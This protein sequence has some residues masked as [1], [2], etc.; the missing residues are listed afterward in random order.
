[1]LISKELTAAELTPTKT[2]VCKGLKPGDTVEVH[3]VH[4]S[5]DVTPDQTLIV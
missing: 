3:W 4:S 1:M 2:N 5:A